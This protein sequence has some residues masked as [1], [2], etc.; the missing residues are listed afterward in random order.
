MLWSR[1]IR[2]LDAVALTHAHH[3]HMGGLPAI[4]RNFHP[5]N[6]GWGKILRLLLTGRFWTRP[7]IL[8]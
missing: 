2:R 4:L 3:D 7:G 5:R 6:F 8:G 1:G